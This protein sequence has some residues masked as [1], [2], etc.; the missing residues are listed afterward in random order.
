[1]FEERF[2]CQTLGQESQLRLLEK[3]R[4]KLPDLS[5]LH[6][7]FLAS[8][9]VEGVLFLH[10]EPA[11][12]TASAKGLAA[13]EQEFGHILAKLKKEIGKWDE[14][15]YALKIFNAREKG[16]WLQARDEG[17]VKQREAIQTYQECR[18]PTRAFENAVGASTFTRASHVAWTE[19]GTAPTDVSSESRLN[20]EIC[21][22]NLTV[23]GCRA[24]KELKTALETFVAPALA[25]NP[26]ASCAIVLAPNLSEWGNQFH[27][28]QIVQHTDACEAL[29]RDPEYRGVYRRISFHFSEDE[30][31]AQT[32]RPAFHT[33]WILLSDVRKGPDLLSLFSTSTLWGR[34]TVSNI[35]PLP[36][37]KYVDP[38]NDPGESLSVQRAEIVSKPARRRQWLSGSDFVAKTMGQL[39]K[40]TKVRPSGFGRAETGRKH[41]RFVLQKDPTSTKTQQ[42]KSAPN[43]VVQKS[44]T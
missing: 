6:F 24:C 35:A 37:S 41:I 30:M 3:T 43:A 34:R 25:G 40:G 15:Q 33:G 28:D 36:I 42:H 23:A 32:R 38:F 11:A 7:R 22:L 27:D 10:A 2:E 31:A 8:L 13:E 26:V 14:S 17:K 16:A 9:G 12:S 18:F 29:L 1:M 39:W 19:G 5:V 4:C 20:F 21:W 44:M